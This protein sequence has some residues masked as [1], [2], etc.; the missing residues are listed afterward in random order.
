MTKPFN[1][2]I[3]A[4]DIPIEE[5]I[6]KFPGHLY[7]KDREGHYL[8]V[9]EEHLSSMGLSSVAEAIGKTDFDLIWRDQAQE[10]REI[11]LKVMETGERYSVEELGDTSKGQHR[12]FVSHKLPLRN[13]NGDIVGVIGTSVDISE[14]V[15]AREALRVAK[16]KAERASQA[17]SEFIANMSHDLR[18]PLA[19]I[20]SLVEDIIGKTTDKA[21]LDDVRLL[22]NASGDLLYLIDSI[23]EVVRTD[24]DQLV[25]EMRQ[26]NLKNLVNN[27]INMLQPKINDKKLH[28][29][30]EYDNTL[31]EYVVGYGLLLQRVLLNLI[32]NA[33]KFTDIDGKIGLF[34]RRLPLKHQRTILQVTV[35]DTGIGI[36]A[37][38]MDF[39]F[40][41]F[42][43]ISSSYASTHKGAGVGLYMVKRYIDQM[44]GTM[45]VDS[46]EGEGSSFCLEI[47]VDVVDVPLSENVSETPSK[48]VK[49][50]SNVA[51]LLVEDNLIA[52]RS[53]SSKFTD[54][55]CTIQLAKDGK[56]AQELFSN[57]QFD[58]I[59]LD[60]G[61][62]DTD[63]R[64]L[65]Q[66][67]RADHLNPNSLVPI[68]FL[69]AHDTS[70]NV[71]LEEFGGLTIFKQKPLLAKDAKQLLDTYLV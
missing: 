53:Q 68:V 20:Q 59:I 35:T 52:Q 26:F 38:K 4:N 58:I 41:K 14:Q 44:G 39:I 22:Q 2:D 55:G 56:E 5:I 37:D 31:P 54:L 10:L 8:G 15:A 65:A 29:K 12:T 23:L 33:I 66:R 43:R 64:T 60:L 50:Y 46:K 61:L 69:T 45:M 48:S 51:V 32:G 19:G 18:T 9:N 62:P 36:P 28:M 40:E 34:L 49:Q 42:S 1:I 16:L 27:V 21:I 63:G 57:H 3:D 6:S 70:I 67:F 17:K 24:A 25:Y 11:D 7:W 13:R 30:V 47:P 71:N